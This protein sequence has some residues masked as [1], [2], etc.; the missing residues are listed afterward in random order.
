MRV[1]LLFC[2][3]LAGTE[4]LL[5][6]KFGAVLAVRYGNCLL[7]PVGASCVRV[8]F[9]CGVRYHGSMRDNG[10]VADTIRDALVAVLHGSNFGVSA[11]AVV[12]EQPD[13]DEHGEY[14]STI[15]LV[16]GAA[17]GRNPREIAE[18]LRDR[19]SGVIE[20]VDR[21]EVAGPG[22]LNFY[23]SRDFF[24]T[25][26]IGACA[27]GEEWGRG[28]GFAGKEVLLE[29]TSPNLFKQLHVGNLVGNIIG[30]SIARLFEM[31]GAL[32]R[33]V[34][35]PSDIGLTVAKGVWGLQKNNGDAGNIGDLGKAY[36]LGNEAYEQGIEGKREIEEINRHLYAGDN[37]ALQDVWVR[38]KQTSLNHLDALC[39]RLGTVF[40]T[41]IFESD[42]GDIGRAKVLEHVA[43]GIF[44]EDDGAVIFRGE[45]QGLHTRVFLNSQGLPT[46]EAKDLG[47]FIRKQ[48][49]YPD[50]DVSIVVT[51][52][53]Q[54]EYFQ[55]L[56]AALREIFPE[57]QEKHFEHI[58]T[59]FLTLSSGKMSSRKGNVLTGELLL[60]DL[61]EEA[62]KRA[63]ETRSDDTDALVDQIAV[64]ALKYQI[65]R[66]T[67]GS[68][69]VFDKQQAFSF[70]GDSGPYLQYTY[71]RSVSVLQKAH[72]VGIPVLTK[73]E[74]GGTRIPEVVYPVER[75]VCRFP[76]VVSVS[77][78]KRSPHHLVVYLTELAGAFNSFYAGERIA[79]SADP[80]SSYKVTVT[81][82][83]AHTLR[84]GLRALGVETPE[85]M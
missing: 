32:V 4:N 83:V 66:R 40:D 2:I 60:A 3:V 35:Y 16:V 7:L 1:F 54:R 21:I 6:L 85:K 80:F 8:L 41:V 62:L 67:V 26:C 28:D 70:E 22:F 50:W 24:Y 15:A 51:G 81:Q 45:K 17:I 38:G 12:V 69:I 46:Y 52:S 25:H 47:N 27:A 75:L 63:K 23:L 13:T 76:E 58:A 59:G 11:D 42:V 61:C 9:I 5:E 53:E 68:D 37:S 64:A 39:R 14:A 73:K 55:V 43:D 49:V 18:D 74:D 10:T 29:Y 56:T 79:D 20:V 77:L 48:E 36:R 72:D 30:E 78:R 65:L 84:N 71:A 33:R 57:L 19:L 31:S 34:N 44:E 82:A